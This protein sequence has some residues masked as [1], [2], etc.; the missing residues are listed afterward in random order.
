[1]EKD[2][3]YAYKLQHIDN[4]TFENVQR[5]ARTFIND[6]PQPMVDKIYE[7]LNRGV[8]QLTTEPQMLVYLH[9]FGSMHQAKL[10]YAFDHLPDAFREQPKVNIIDYGCGQA[11]GT[12]CYA[13]FLHE[14]G[15]E[16][17]IGTITLIEPSEICLKRAALHAKAFF[18]DAEIRTICNGFD[19]LEADDILSD[20]STPTLH[21]LSNVLDIL[22][23]DLERFAKLIDGQLCGYNQFVCVGPYFNY[24]D[25]DERMS[26]FA[27]LLDG[28]VSYSK[29]F[30]KGELKSGKTWTAQIVCFADG[31]LEEE[32]LSTEVT[33][34]EIRNGIE[35]EFGVVY[36]KDGKRLLKCKNRNLSEYQIKDGTK[37]ICDSAFEECESL[38]KILIPESGMSIGIGAFAFCVSLHKITIPDSITTIGEGA[39]FSCENLKQIT[40]PNTVTT[41]EDRTFED[42]KTLQHIVIPN[43]LASIGD[44]AFNGCKALRQITIPYTVK[45]IGKSPFA[46]CNNLQ[47]KSESS[48]FVLIN[49]ML[50]D[51]NEHLLISYNGN[52][53][54]LE[55]PDLI[56]TIENYAFSDCVFL[57]RIT[58]SHSVTNIGRYAFSNCKS[59]Q[60][61]I[62]PESVKSI[63]ERTF[64]NCESLQQI[65]IPNSVSKINGS[66]FDGCKNLISI[67]IPPLANIIATLNYINVNNLVLVLNGGL[68]LYCENLK[69]IIVNS[70][71]PNLLSENG[72]LFDK[73]K[74]TIIR[75]PENIETKTFHIPHSVIR[76]EKCAFFN[77]K[78]LGKI[79]IP[80]SVT[81][82]DDFAFYGCDVLLYNE[83]DNAYYLGNNDNPYLYLA[84]AKSKDIET[85]T[86]NTN[87]KFIGDRAFYLCRKMS[88]IDIPISVTSIGSF[89]FSHCEKLS[90]TC[91]DNN[92]RSFK[93]GW[94]CGRPVKVR[95]IELDTKRMA[96]F[97]NTY[98]YNIGSSRNNDSWF[99]RLFRRK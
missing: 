24:S 74:M 87:C 99:S 85:C 3:I 42:C 93:D 79:V 46:K 25:K 6:L 4:P 43:F 59:L 81:R 22:D 15:I 65:T 92:R 73:N 7:D 11:I 80:N 5:L 16:Q 44:D 21:I 49:N 50:I 36:S 67:T 97:L 86:I 54:S 55:I 82:V 62:I 9:S 70:D 78:N 29:I 48:R 71:N 2:T 19:D 88:T 39:F 17:N 61:I 77:C 35:D 75:C 76:I 91:K 28:N 8:D 60:Q 27:E 89:A 41:I 57:K 18:P 64:H 20:E 1:M 31:E 12:M 14:N 63:E 38:Q 30:E 37:V 10:R 13:D 34:E 66:A 56:T 53:E 45:H 84:K 72:V 26:R 33:E 51:R 94:N 58:I 90:I 68:L 98:K 69:E 23:F 40:I 95:G 83:Y 52:E 47:L 96:E 32:E